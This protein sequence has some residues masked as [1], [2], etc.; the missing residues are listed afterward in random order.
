[1]YSKNKKTE[2][3]IK[4][5]KKGRDIK[6]TFKRFWVRIIQINDFNKTLHFHIFSNN[7]SIKKDAEEKIEGILIAASEGW[8]F[9]SNEEAEWCLLKGMK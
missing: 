3:E 9:E 4:V 8:K 6:F 7:I 1:M 2:K 5:T